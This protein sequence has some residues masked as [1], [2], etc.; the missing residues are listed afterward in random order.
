MSRVLS[1]AGFQVT[2]IGR[3]WVIPEASANRSARKSFGSNLALITRI[4]TEGQFLAFRF[5]RNGRKAYAIKSLESLAEVLQTDA[6]SCK[7]CVCREVKTEI[8]A[9]RAKVK[10]F[11]CN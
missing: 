5:C 9:H 11:I 10:A 1:L 4:L 8:P 7:L 6:V 3:F 2:L